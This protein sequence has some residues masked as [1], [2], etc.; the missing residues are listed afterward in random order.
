M[1]VLPKHAINP[2]TF[3]ETTLAPPIG[4]GPYVVG[5]VEAGK[6]LTLVRNPDY[7]G[8]ELPINRGFWNFDEIRF[9]YYRDANSYHEAFKRGLF[10]LRTETDPAR[11]QTAYDF[12]AMR[13][14]R[15]VKETLRQRPAEGQLLLRL[16]HAPP[17]LC[18][19][20][21]ARGDLAV[22]RLRMDQPQSVLRPVSAQRQLFRRLRAVGARTSGRCAR[23][24]PAGA[25]SRRGSPRRARRHLV[26][27]GRA[28]APAAIAPCCGGR[29]TCCPRPAT[30]CAPASWSRRAAATPSP[31][32]S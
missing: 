1:P 20:S 31:S 8:R 10:D 26:A 5:K 28:T 16:Q 11:W 30:S 19:Y 6:S 21:R 25:V 29:S 32:R 12:P 13:D 7:W 17:G 22:V 14:G 3:E 27:A 15:V 24:R 18:G 9:D 4:S 23:A 2:E